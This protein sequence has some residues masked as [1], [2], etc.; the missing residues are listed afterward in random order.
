[1]F[2]PAAAPLPGVNRSRPEPVTPPVPLSPE[3]QQFLNFARVEKG[4]AA[5]SILS[6]R[7]DLKEFSAFLSRLQ[8][9]PSSVDRDDIRSF[10]AALYDR[11]LGARSVARH[12]VSVR[13]L[14]RFLVREGGLTAIPRS[15]S[16]RPGWASR[17]PGTLRRRRLTVCWS[18]PM[19]PPP[20]TS[21]Q[22]D[23][24]TAL[25]HRDAGFGT[26]A[27][28][29]S[30]F[31]YG[32]GIIRCLGKGNKERLIPVGKSALRAVEAYLARGRAVLAGKRNPPWLFLN[33]RGGALSR[34][35]FW[36]ILAAYGRRAGLAT[37]LLRTWFGIRLPRTCLSGAP[38]CDR[39]N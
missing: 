18:S 19:S 4:L 1:M 38:I 36:K 7:C 26:C 24:G 29:R 5:N 20:G 10:L 34:V 2:Q 11:Q 23:A 31:R 37:S 14:F 15:M 8:K 9:T 6:Y 22:S 3:V 13:S 33:Q 21:R 25:R 32:L 27:C 28:G 35:G 12:L 17:Y 16:R 39:F 30:G